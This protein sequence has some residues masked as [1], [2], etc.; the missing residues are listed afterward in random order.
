[1]NWAKIRDEESIKTEV[2]I[3]RKELIDQWYK[4]V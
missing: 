1:M 3:K 2:K 4:S